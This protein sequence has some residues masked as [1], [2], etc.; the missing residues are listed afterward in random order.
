MMPVSE[1]TKTGWAWL[2]QPT[3]SRRIAAAMIL[4]LVAFQ[5]QAL[6]QIMLLSKP[7]LRL[8]GTRWLAEQAAAAANAAFAVPPKARA[9]L[10]RREADVSGFTL[11]WSPIRPESERDQSPSMLAA[12]LA[13]TVQVVMGDNAQAV[14]TQAS[15]LRFKFPAANTRITIAEHEVSF[16]INRAAIQKG[17]PDVLI[18]AGIRV[19]IQGKDNSWVIAETQ[20]YRDAALGLSLPYGPLMVGGLIIALVSTIMARRLTAPLDR[21]VEAAGR[22]GT[23]REP[24]LVKT[25]GMHEFA[26]VGHAFEDMQQRLLRFVEDRTRILAAIS[27]DLRS[28]LTRLTLTAEQCQGEAERTALAAEIADMQSMVESTLAF[29]SGEARLVP[30]K[31]TDIAAL[32]ISLVDEAADAGKPCTYQGPDHI[33]TMGHP[34]SL[35]RAFWNVIDNGLKYGHAARVRLDV[36]DA[37]ITIAV[38]DDGPGIPEDS[39]DDMFAPFRRLDPARGHETPG[40]GLGLTIARDVIQSHGGTITLSN[41][42]GG[43][44]T[45]TMTLP[46]R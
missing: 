11:S 35:K 2:R 3:L 15:T 14:E 18:P 44:L 8:V 42:I 28:S 21:L 25:E 17:E 43:G 40:V 31:P 38:E 16:P 45:V 33:E 5:A 36:S 7:E 24:V 46:R 32:M 34:L 27:H 1:T 26:A 10:L 9:A 4:S 23:A 22:I 41:R 30:T 19:W 13:A 6:L 29:A 12:S 39:F 20:G 37:A